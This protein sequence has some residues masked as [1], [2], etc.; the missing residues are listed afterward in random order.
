LP[1][2]D[3]LKDLILQAI[4]LNKDGVKVTVVKKAPAAK[5]DLVVP[6]DL[7]EAFKNNAKAAEV[8]HDFSNSHRKEYVQWITE[9]KT[10][11]TRQKRIAQA[12]EMME[13]G[14][15]RNWKYQR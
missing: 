13:E 6:D 7:I 11:A 12:I 4:A 1:A 9:A 14:K 2:D 5:T 8:F 3:I 15:S 10:D